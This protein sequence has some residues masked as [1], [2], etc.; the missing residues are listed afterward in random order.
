MTAATGYRTTFD[1]LWCG[2]AWSTRGD[3]DLEG[4]AQL[5]P[6]CLG[7]AGSNPFLAVRLRQAL[8]ARG[9]S[10]SG[11]GSAAAAPGSASV[12]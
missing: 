11:A 4:W 2:A 7:K 10:A 6:T 3:D 5:C 1:C 8:A 12:A 9:A